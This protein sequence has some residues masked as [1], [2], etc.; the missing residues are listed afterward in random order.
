MRKLASIQ[1]VTDVWPVEKSRALDGVRVLGWMAVVPRGMFKVG[2]KCLFLE[3]DSIVPKDMPQFAFMADS[4]WLVKTR[5]MYGQLSQG[6]CLRLE[7]FPWLMDKPVGT[8]VTSMIGSGITK[9]DDSVPKGMQGISKG[10]FPH[11]I[12]KTD[13]PR[14]Q[15]A[16]GLVLRHQDDLWY[17]TE[18]LDG[19]SFTAY[20]NDGDFGVCSRNNDLI[21]SDDNTYW[22][23]ANRY[24]LPLTLPQAAYMR[25]MRGQGK[26][27]AIQCEMVGPRIQG[28]R[29]KFLSPELFM[30]SAYDIDKQAYLSFLE[31][32]EL[33]IHLGIKTVPVLQGKVAVSLK[34]MS[35]DDLVAMSTM[36]STLYD[37]PAEGIVV[38]TVDYTPD[39]KY[40]HASFKVINPEFSL[41]ERPPEDEDE[42]AYQFSLKDRPPEDE[43]TYQDE[44]E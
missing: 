33:S 29:Y 25:G 32:H 3:A 15:T 17:V 23:T 4:K 27:I 31:L 21:Q 7:D 44:E 40:P 30:F 12:P 9:Y 10:N 13:E 2:D 34:G 24:S 11:F 26:N 19:T 14:I 28:N 8:D 35:V 38:R 22:R 6:L 36:K 1:H 16:H 41:K 18:K 20:Y 42:P 39:K 43:P 37:G 5:K